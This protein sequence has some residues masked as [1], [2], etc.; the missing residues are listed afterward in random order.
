MKIISNK[1]YEY[2]EKELAGYKTAKSM[3]EQNLEEL[4]NELEAKDNAYRGLKREMDILLENNKQIADKY[5]IT[6]KEEKRLKTLLT[7]NKIS[8]KKKEK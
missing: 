3:L 7:K 8:Y 6:K 1:K 2:M 4:V 5:E